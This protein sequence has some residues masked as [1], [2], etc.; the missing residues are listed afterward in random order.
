MVQG[1][2]ERTAGLDKGAAAAMPTRGKLVARICA[3]GG[4]SGKIGSADYLTNMGWT[5]DC[6]GQGGKVVQGTR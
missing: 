2:T 6:P 1:L 5:P 3:T 4:S